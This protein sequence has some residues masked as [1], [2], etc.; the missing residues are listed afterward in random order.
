MTIPVVMTTAG[1]TPQTAAALLSQLIAAVTATNPGYTANLPAS[2][3]EDISSTDVGALLICDSAVSELINSMTPYGANAFLLTQLGVLLGIPLGLNSNTSANVV[4]TGTPGY[5]ISPGFTVSDGANQYTV[6]DGTVIGV[7]GTST[8][9]FV[10]AVNSGSFAVP[11][12]SITQ[13]ITSVPS[14]ISL[15]V[16][17][18]LAGAPGLGTETEESYR[19]RV[20]DAN[21]ASAQGTPRFLRTLLGKIP[22]VTPNL[23]SVLQQSN[24]LWEVIVGPGGDANAIAFAIYQAIFDINQLTGSTLQA[25]A[26]TAANPGVVTTNLNHG[27]IT[28]R[29]VTITG[30]ANANYNGTFTATVIDEKTFSIGANTSAF[31]AYTGGGVVTPNLRNVVASLIDY[32]DTYTIP[33]V[34]PPQQ[35]VTMTVLWNTTAVNF[36]NSSAV[37]QL[38]A[39]AIAAYVN[40]LAVGVPMNL[41][42]L[43]AVFQTAVASVLPA[44]LLTRMAFTVSINGVVTAPTAGTGV[45]SGD[46]ESYFS[47]TS[48]SISITQG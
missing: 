20:Q 47:T 46:P 26:I 3:I 39:P 30:S 9:T 14:G 25:T 17:N 29:V 8:S 34:V 33:Y 28:G 43:Q 10:L 16:T 38:A 40:G 27:Y 18:P 37:A 2:L 22:G 48:A 45:I 44:Q 32:P 15:T 31:G 23:V 1:R 21:L 41:F 12:N 11:A 5:I 6:V 19:T 36:V 13:I 35:T 42:E 7:G 4:F 24:G